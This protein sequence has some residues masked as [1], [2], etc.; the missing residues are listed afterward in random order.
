MGIDGAFPSKDFDAVAMSAQMAFEI[1]PQH[2]PW[3]GKLLDVDEA[4]FATAHS[5]WSD[6]AAA[7]YEW[8]QR[9]KPYGPTRWPPAFEIETAAEILRKGP[10]GKV[11]AVL[12]GSTRAA[13]K[14]TLRLGFHDGPPTPEELDQLVS[15][16]RELV[17]F[18]DDKEIA[19]LLGAAWQGLGTPFQE[20]AGGIMK[21][22]FI[23]GIL[24]EFP[25]GDRVA[26]RVLS[27]T[28]DELAALGELAPAGQ[29]FRAIGDEHRARFGDRPIRLVVSEVR[30]EISALQSLLDADRDRVLVGVDLSYGQKL[31]TA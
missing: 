11:L 9:L 24:A 2:R 10:L 19:L 7:D 16:I 17:E 22:G 3:I 31:V 14:L 12:T 26:T 4:G 5:R 6:L 25:G 18:E 27:M 13:R 21:R 23:R 20:I 1:A 8:R 28:P 15:H 30:A 29:M